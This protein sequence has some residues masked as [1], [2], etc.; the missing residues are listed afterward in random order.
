MANHMPAIG[1]SVRDGVACRAATPCERPRVRAP[2]RAPETAESRTERRRMM[3]LLGFLSG[4]HQGGP[5]LFVPIG[6]S[7]GTLAAVPGSSLLSSLTR[8][9][10]RPLWASNEFRNQF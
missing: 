6:R 5:R 3:N 9:T 7:D 1:W 4:G 2:V 8:P 10:P